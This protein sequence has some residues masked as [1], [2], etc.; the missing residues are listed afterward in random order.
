MERIRENVAPKEKAMPE[1]VTVHNLIGAP[2]KI[3][4]QYAQ[5]CED[6]F[7][8]IRKEQ[9]LCVSCTGGR[10]PQPVSEMV[11]MVTSFRGYP[12]FPLTDCPRK[13]GRQQ[14]REYEE[15]LKEAGIPMIYKGSTFA[16]YEE[17]DGNRMALQLAQK[18][19]RERDVEK[20]M[21][22]YGARGT[23]KTLLASIVGNLFLQ[24][25]KRVIFANPYQLRYQIRQVCNNSVRQPLKLETCDLL[26]LDDLGSERFSSWS[27]G[28]L[29]RI[30]DSRYQEKK[31]TIVTSNYGLKKLE[32]QLA[33][34]NGT[35]ESRDQDAASRICSRLAGMLLPV[36][37]YGLDRRKLEKVG[38]LGRVHT[39]KE[40]Q[41]QPVR[42]FS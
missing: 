39:G 2:A 14:Q 11:H 24:Q 13:R 29:S 16:H 28:I 3:R 26:I 33:Q 30:I 42:L 12:Y 9:K 4:K 18:M 25:G 37:F 36:P 27:L 32:A 23:G 38:T 21:Y 31:L 40:N 6:E 34:V 7:Q 20:G 10:C 35:L 22:L 41:D 8:R 17:N 19:V 5:N 1:Y 15:R